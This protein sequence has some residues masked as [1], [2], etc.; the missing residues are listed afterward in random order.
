MNTQNKEKL[1]KN[2]YS[3]ILSLRLNKSQNIQKKVDNILKNVESSQTNDILEKIIE[4]CKKNPDLGKLIVKYVKL[5]GYV[6]NNN[7]KNKIMNSAIIKLENIFKKFPNSEKEYNEIF[8]TNNNNI[9]TIAKLNKFIN[10]YKNDPKTVT[11]VNSL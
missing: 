8:S 1:K 5:H 4:V 3:E 2:L 7:T 11:R 10:Q 6:L 9:N